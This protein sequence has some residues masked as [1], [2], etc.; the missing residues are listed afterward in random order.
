M[1]LNPF[2]TASLIASGRAPQPTY[3]LTERLAGSADKVKQDIATV[4]EV[5]EASDDFDPWDDTYIKAPKWMRVGEAVAVVIDLRNST[6]L[7]LNKRAASTASIYEAATGTAVQLIGMFAPNFV[8]IQGDGAFALFWGDR[9]YERALCAGITVKTFSEVHLVPQLNEKWDELPE[10]GFKVALAASPL[11]VKRIGI[12][13]TDHQEPVWPG[14][15]VNYAAK[16]AQAASPGQLVVTDSIWRYFEDNE[17]VVY[18]C[19][20][21]GGPQHSL[22]DDFEVGVLPEDDPER[23]GRVLTSRWCSVHGEEFCNAICSGEKLRPGLQDTVKS[24]RQRELWESA[25]RKKALRARSMR[26]GLQR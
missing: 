7:G 5:V 15:A 18:T 22:W 25:M 26:Q 21:D 11:L 6:H 10:T 2:A 3:A 9:R 4:P 14:K 16:A 24:A 8:A 23:Y 13:R 19:G 17:F 1:T 20:C 12:P